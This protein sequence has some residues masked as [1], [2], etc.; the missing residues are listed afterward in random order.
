MSHHK[1]MTKLDFQL[2]TAN[3]WQYSWKGSWVLA[4]PPQ[5]SP[6]PT[7]SHPLLWDPDLLFIL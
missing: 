1:D 4:I 7:P 5:P 6:S 2:K 3:Y